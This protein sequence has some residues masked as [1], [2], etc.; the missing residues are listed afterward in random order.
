[1]S[2]SNFS[3]LSNSHTLENKIDC[4]VEAIEN[5]RLNSLS[6]LV[7]T[8]LVTDDGNSFPSFNGKEYT[9][10]D[11]DNVVCRW[12]KFAH[13]WDFEISESGKFITVVSIPENYRGNCPK[14]LVNALNL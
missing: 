10:N 5:S 9:S 11:N 3:Y 14:A 7:D 8:V 13:F 12:N 4:L 6:D 2:L 1:M